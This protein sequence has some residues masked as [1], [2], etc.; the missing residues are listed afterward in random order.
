MTVMLFVFL[1][2]KKI[3][4]NTQ[5]GGLKIIECINVFLIDFLF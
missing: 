3:R 5:H 1:I 4:T 2:K